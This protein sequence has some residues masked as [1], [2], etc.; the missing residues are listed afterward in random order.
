[1]KKEN[2]SLDFVQMEHDMLKFWEETKLFDKIVEKNKNGK[3]F[4]FLDGP[5]TANNPAGVHHIWGRTLKDMQLKYHAM[6]G[7]SQQFQNGFDAQ[8]LWVEVE[9]EKQLGLNGKPE[10]IEY[11]LEN[12]TNKCM[13]RVNHFAKVITDQSIRMGQF[14]DWDNS[15]FTNS[16]KNELGIWAFLKECDKR[17]W[18]IRKYRPMAWCPRCGTSLSDHEMSGSYSDRTH[19]TIYAKLPVK[20]KDFKLVAWTT[21]PWTLTANCALAVNKDLKYSLVEFEGE[22]LVVG[23]PSLK[24]FS[25]KAKVLKEFGG[26][27]LVGLEYE[28]CFPELEVQNFV[29]RVYN[30]DEVSDEKGSCIVHIAPG[31]GE[32][33]FELGQENDI[34]A[35]CPINDQGIILDNYGEFSNISTVDVAEKVIE[36]L[37]KDNKLL[38]T[39]K[40]THSYA[41]CWRCKTDIVYKLITSW[42]IKVDELR[43]LL[44]KAIDDVEFS[45]EYA[46]KRMQDWIMN[47][48]D[49][50]IS[51][52]RFYGLPLPFY[53]CEKCGKVQ[54]LMLY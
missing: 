23:T 54:S 4:K 14:M 27:E 13:E 42:C 17:G 12:F 39:S 2:A 24:M 26:E 6:K 36:R 50:P 53:V 31:C 15:Y 35:V 37:K 29:H 52:S 22:K 30:W 21:T 8:G 34:P 10:I 48:G 16:D 32:S 49:W 28:T 3:R 5:M 51:R 47:M 40:I 7:E 1:M 46:K 19:T 43:P 45:P 44:L 9:V 11:G 33:D 25:G 41:H 18:I 38:F 20:N